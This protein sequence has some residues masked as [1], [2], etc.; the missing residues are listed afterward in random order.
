MLLALAAIILSGC[1]WSSNLETQMSNEQKTSAEGLNLYL[2]YYEITEVLFEQYGYHPDYWYID[3]EGCKEEHSGVSNI[4]LIDLDSDGTEEF[5]CL[6]WPSAEEMRI[7]IY[8]YFNQQ[9]ELLLDRELL[10]GVDNCKGFEGL[11]TQANGLSG[12]LLFDQD[13]TGEQTGI[14]HETFWGYEKNGKALTA[15]EFTMR[16]SEGFGSGD[17]MPEW[18]IT[19]YWVDGKEVDQKIYEQEI[20]AFFEQMISRTSPNEWNVYEQI[21]MLGREAGKSVE[22][23]AQL[24][25]IM[26]GAKTIKTEEV[27]P[28]QPADP[29]IDCG[30]A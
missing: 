18:I 23:V 7:Q 1:S 4:C 28:S 3:D 30:E 6:F 16:Y 25:R 12:C 21:R 26:D 8:T 27:L 5:I 11:Y 22:E 9:C 20:D 17:P 19:T 14:P 13:I 29:M 24:T 2:A 15:H 10:D